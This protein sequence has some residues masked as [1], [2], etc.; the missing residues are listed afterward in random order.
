MT[1]QH[2]QLIG[3]TTILLF[4]GSEL[5]WKP[6]SCLGSRGGI[7]PPHPR[8]V[9]GGAGGDLRMGLETHFWSDHGTPGSSHLS[10]QHHQ[11]GKHG[12]SFRWEKTSRIPKLEH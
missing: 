5:P 4:Q 9:C 7:P 6:L 3:N 10:Q 1:S 12:E 2:L 11:A 8:E